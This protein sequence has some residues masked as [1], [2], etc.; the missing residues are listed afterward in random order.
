MSRRTGPLRATWAGPLGLYR[1][2]TTVVHRVPAGT[3]LL[4]LLLLGAAV[5][6]ARGWVTSLASFGAVLV[7]TFLAR[8]PL[9]RT[10]RG[11]LPVVVVAVLLAAYQWWARGWAVGLEVAVDLVTVVL[12]ATVVTATSPFNCDGV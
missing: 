11:L 12:A 9:V 6:L 4:V 2:G 5:V 10:V 3:Q 1:P 7:V 8:S